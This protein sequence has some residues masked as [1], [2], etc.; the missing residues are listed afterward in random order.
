MSACDFI[1]LVFLALVI[2]GWWMEDR[3]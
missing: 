3:A 2:V 1:I